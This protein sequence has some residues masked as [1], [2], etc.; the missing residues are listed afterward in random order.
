LDF[1]SCESELETPEYCPSR[2]FST[3]AC[4]F[5]GAV[6]FTR[7]FLLYNCG[8]RIFGLKSKVPKAPG[9]VGSSLKGN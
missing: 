9:E 6:G 8:E 4:L 2:V 7:I 5:E 1:S 3:N